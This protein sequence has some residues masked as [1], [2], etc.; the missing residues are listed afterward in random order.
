MDFF[1]DENFTGIAGVFY[2]GKC[3]LVL[4]KQ[5]CINLLE[6][7]VA[8]APPVNPST[9]TSTTITPAGTP[10]NISIYNNNVN[11]N[12]NSNTNEVFVTPVEGTSYSGDDFMALRSGGRYYNQPHQ[13]Q[14]R[15]RVNYQQSRRAYHP[16]VQRRPVIQPRT[17]PPGIPDRDDSRPPG[18][19]IDA[20][21]R[22]MPPGIGG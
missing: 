5:I 7:P 11:T 12:N 14:V 1:H 17:M 9:T 2:Y 4:F 13:P 10:I 3:R 8:K 15:F 22:R 16:P 6:V 19:G 21:R 18:G 20:D